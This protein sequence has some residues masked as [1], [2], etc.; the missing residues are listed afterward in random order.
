MS[1][2]ETLTESKNK[3]D[4]LL[5]F[6]NNTTGNSDTNIGDAI[7]TLCDGYEQGG[8]EVESGT[9]TIEKT[10]RGLTL[11]TTKQ[12]EIY[13]LSVENPKEFVSTE[14]W[15]YYMAVVWKGI[16]SLIT[17]KYTNGNSATALFNSYTINTD[18]SITINTTGTYWRAGIV[19]NWKAF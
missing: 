2:K 8:E 5:D 17:S 7:K 9:I 11:P 16:F 14:G 6:A 12:H 4:A 18:N 19:F 3:L 10:S 15:T 13:I 1:I